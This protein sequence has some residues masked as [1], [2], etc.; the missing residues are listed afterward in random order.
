[1][2]RNLLTSNS[3]KYRDTGQYTLLYASSFSYQHLKTEEHCEA[4]VVTSSRR[5]RARAEVLPPPTSRELLVALL[6][7]DEDP[8]HP[9]FRT[10]DPDFI[11][12]ALGGFGCCVCV[13][14]REGGNRRK[15]GDRESSVGEEQ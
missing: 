3:E 11:T 9:I 10:Q 5:R 13:C 14:W 1:M 4:L 15:G 6:S 2:N 12:T 7:D 8:V